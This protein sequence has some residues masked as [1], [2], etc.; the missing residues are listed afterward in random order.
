MFSAIANVSDG[1]SSAGRRAPV[2]AVRHSEA[3]GRRIR[4]LPR[5]YTLVSCLT[6][7]KRSG[8]K[9]DIIRHLQQARTG[10]TQQDALQE[11]IAPDAD[12]P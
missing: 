1:S 11:A 3:A 8:P 5:R 7:Q 9:S 4:R 10:P 12:R 6:E 2:T